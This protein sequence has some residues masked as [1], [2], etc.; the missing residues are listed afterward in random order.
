VCLKQARLEVLRA[1]E[2]RFEKESRLREK[3]EGGETTYDLH[4]LRVVVEKYRR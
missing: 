1:S 3:L 4:G 2:A